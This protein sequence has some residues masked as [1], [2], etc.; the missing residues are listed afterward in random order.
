MAQIKL[1]NST[2]E[3]ISVA[4]F[5]ESFKIP[6]TKIVAWKVETLLEEG[7]SSIVNIPGNYEVYVNYSQDSS[8][9]GDPYSGTKSQSINFEGDTAKFIVKEEPGNLISF[10]RVFTDLA[11]NEIHIVNM[12]GFGVWGH[13]LLD[14]KDIYPPELI[15]PG[16]TL[17]EDIRTP[18]KVAVTMDD[19]EPGTLMEIRELS[20]TPIEV[21]VGDNIEI[22][23]SK[24]EGYSIN[25]V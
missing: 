22:T 8:H 23:G 12:A 7:D 2:I 17:M 19:M 10:N 11:E 9:K 14:I 3:K 1:L 16:A 6:S 24:W 4:V 13:I 25:I 18:L 21:S 15:T 20:S 5:K